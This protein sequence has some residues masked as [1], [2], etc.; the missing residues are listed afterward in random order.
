MFAALDAAGRGVP[1]VEVSFSTASGNGRADPRSA[2]TDA[3][4][5]AQTSWTLGALLGGQTLIATAA[6]LSAQA[7]AEATD[8]PS[9]PRVG[10]AAAYLVQAAQD[11][12]GSVPL[13]AGRPARL[14]VFAIA[15]DSATAQFRPLALFYQ[16]ATVDS[17]RLESG[18]LP[19]TMNEGNE[20]ES[21]DAT[22]PGSIVKPGLKMVVELDPD[23]EVAVAN[24]SA[25]RF[26][27]TGRADVLVHE[28]AS[29]PLTLVPVHFATT[30]NT[31]ANAAVTTRAADMAGDDTEGIISYTRNVLPI[32]DIS[33][34][35]RQAYVTWVDTLPESPRSVLLSELS[36][37]RQADGSSEY[38]HGLFSKPSVA[39]DLDQWRA[40]G[41]AYKPGYIGITLS[42][43][44]VNGLARPARNVAETLAHELG[45]NL[46]LGHA[47]CGGAP[48]SDPDFPY[49]DGSV[50]AYGYS[51]SAAFV[52]GLVNPAWR[53]VMSYCNPQWISDYFFKKA[54]NYRRAFRPRPGRAPV[55]GGKTLLLWGSIQDGEMRLEPAFASDGPVKLPESAGP[56]RVEGLATNGESLFRLA[57][58]PDPDAYGGSGFVF[59]LPFEEAW[60]GALDRIELVGPEGATAV[61]RAA[62][63]RSAMLI[64]GATGQVRSIVRNWSGVL[65]AA[66]GARNTVV[67]RRGLPR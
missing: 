12:V 21:F 3:R 46:S 29:F 59:A 15:Q 58:S 48:N 65:P 44:S 32:G 37:V 61:D 26:P 19:A 34:T 50:G 54:M 16:G 2:A 25:T 52:S 67:I 23:G 20:D 45:H 39:A 41:T 35:A 47:P 1:G 30:G 60:T 4:G 51:F 36:A 27:A 57:F 62:G 22:I 5:R 24:G 7:T 40:V 43:Y 53:D 14:R 49:S 28:L 9:P 6:G 38:Y 33:V 66:F 17:V 64:D 13:V 10:I 63:E 18:A 56:Y 55:A 31:G 8:T 11:S 42:H